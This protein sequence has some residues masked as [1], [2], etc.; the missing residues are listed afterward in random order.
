MGPIINYLFVSEKE[1]LSPIQIKKCCTQSVFNVGDQLD[2]LLEL[3]VP[4]NIFNFPTKEH[5]TTVPLY[6]NPKNDALISLRNT[7]ELNNVVLKSCYL[8][9]KCVYMGHKV[10][11]ISMI[12]TL[13]IFQIFSP[14]L[15]Y[16]LQELKDFRFDLESIEVVYRNLNNTK[17]DILMAHFDHLNMASRFAIT[18][19][20]P[21]FSS[22]ESLTLPENLHRQFRDHGNFYKTTIEVVE[23]SIFEFPIQVSKSS[24]VASP[25]SMFGMDLQRSTHVKDFIKTLNKTKISVPKLN[26]IA[27]YQGIKPI[28]VLFNAL[29]LNKKVAVF[30]NNTSFNIL[31]KFVQTLYLIFNSVFSSTSNLL[32]Y[33]T[34]DYNNIALIKGKESILI[35]TLDFRITSEIHFD[36]L[37]D[38][39]SDIIYVRDAKS[40]DCVS[41]VNEDDSPCNFIPNVEDNSDKLA[42]WKL[43][44]FPQII[45]NKDYPDALLL[46]GYYNIEDTFK[47]PL[48]NIYTPM[49]DQLLDQQLEQLIKHHH[50]DQTL[51]V[52]ITNYLRELSSKVLPAFYHFVMTLQLKEYRKNIVTDN[53]AIT[54]ENLE[55]Q[56]IEYIQANNIIQPFPLNYSFDDKISFLED[57]DVFNFYLQIVDSNTALLELAIMYNSNTFTHS[58]IIPGFLFSWETTLGVVDI[59]LDTHYLIMILDSLIDD[60][61]SESWGL[62]KHLLF[63]IFKTVNA[64]LKTHGTGMDGLTNVLMDFFIQSDSEATSVSNNG[65]SISAGTHIPDSSKSNMSQNIDILEKTGNLGKKRFSKLVLIASLY[66]PVDGPQD[67]V[68]TKKGIRRKDLLMTEFKRFLSTVLNDTFFKDY[69]FAELD[70]YVKLMVND[71]ID[72]HM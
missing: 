61:S 38:L 1:S 48:K 55:S 27:P 23:D 72:Y 62:N 33:P 20:Q 12:T 56:I 28:H 57:P 51:F 67:I 5:S 37:F 29:I 3:I 4:S 70:D 59:R 71:F 31:D 53:L 32:F 17:L 43:S 35:G 69:V 22:N 25:L 34:I 6:L 30:A 44:I 46:S 11:S 26:S 54:R 64:I 66:I 41:F 63:Q 19:L 7:T 14:L 2:S 18:R 9:T 16:L 10:I 8:F 40:Y 39:D 50:D 45:K 60:T 13:P 49:I 47:F 36:V 58:N 68:Q 65:Q 24:I 21:D 42:H 52:A 15:T